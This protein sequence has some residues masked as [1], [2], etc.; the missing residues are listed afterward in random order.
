MLD[1]PL[2]I[3]DAASETGPWSAWPIAAHARVLHRHPAAGGRGRFA[4]AIDHF[5]TAIA[6]RDVPLPAK[7]IA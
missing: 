6:A 2:K 1:D 3:E 7:G 5:E 4:A